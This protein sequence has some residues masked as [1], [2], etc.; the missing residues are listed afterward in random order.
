[1]SP[2]DDRVRAPITDPRIT[3]F[4][5]PL[6]TSQKAI[7]EDIDRTPKA[8]SPPKPPKVKKGKKARVEKSCPEDL[9]K[10]K[11]NYT[12]G[13]ICWAYNMKY[14]CSL[15]MQQGL[16]CVCCFR[17][18]L[19]RQL[20]EQSD[21]PKNTATGAVGTSGIAVEEVS[22]P[23]GGDHCQQREVAVMSGN[24]ED[25]QIEVPLSSSSKP[26]KKRKLGED[27]SQ[28]A[29]LCGGKFHNTNIE[30][31]II[32]EIY[33]G[34]AR[35][36]KMVRSMGFKGVAVD[37]SSKRSCGVD[38]CIFD[39]TDPS[40]LNGLLEYIRQDADRIA[41]IWIAPSCGAASRARE[42][43][44]PGHKACPIS[45]FEVLINPML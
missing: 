32:V 30:D 40:Q 42:R 6:P 19:S 38:I 15:T 1:M 27:V 44:I 24:S 37:H 17:F 36:T 21:G 10:Y 13:R 23:T 3:M 41:L 33:A 25:L 26:S 5:L 34:S 22:H 39:L 43:P 11:M 8:D 18:S 29:S 16:P 9:K 7:K 14:G 12:H 2:L 28:N 31:I 45:R 20:T 4:M 35:L